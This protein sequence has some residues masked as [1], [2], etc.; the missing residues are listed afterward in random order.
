VANAPV[1]RFYKQVDISPE[2]GILLD[3]KP[4]RTPKRA[5]LILPT[6]KLAMAVAAEWAGQGDELDARSMTA[7]GLA[8]AAIDIITPDP[9]GFGAGLAAYGQS[10]VLCYRATE[11]PELV[12]KQ[13]MAWDPMVEWARRRFEVNFLLVS[14][15]MHMPQPGSSIEKL[16]RE[17]AT[18]S[19]YQ[20]AALSPLVTIGGSLII[21]L[22]L[23][24]RSISPARAFDICHLD[25]I[26]Q[27]EK[28]GED[29]FATQ[30][31]D[32]HRAEFMA[33]AAFLRLL[34]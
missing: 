32:A 26:W 34:G 21:G 5:T 23:I 29:H 11:P 7:T 1:K 3:G 27:S 17:V 24:E 33:A 13:D 6:D 22:A 14:G 10:D 15:V 9:V 12:A 19:P 30:T 20:L 4:V 18:L 28:W 2:R 16:V 25:E 31:R 8:N